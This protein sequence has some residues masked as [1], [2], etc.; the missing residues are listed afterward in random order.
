MTDPNNKVQPS[1]IDPTAAA[2][3]AIL[4]NILHKENYQEEAEAI[5]DGMWQEYSD[6][7][8]YY[9]RFESLEYWDEEDEWYDTL[10][11]QYEISFAGKKGANV[12]TTGP[13]K[14]KVNK[15]AERTEAIEKAGGVT[16]G[17]G[18]GREPALPMA[19]AL[20]TYNAYSP[21]S[22]PA[23]TA[24]SAKSTEVPSRAADTSHLFNPTLIMQIVANLDKKYEMVTKN[25]QYNSVVPAAISASDLKMLVAGYDHML[26]TLNLKFLANKYGAHGNAYRIDLRFGDNVPNYFANVGGESM[27]Q[28][29]TYSIAGLRNLL[30]S[31]APIYS[32]LASSHFSYPKAINGALARMRNETGNVVDLDTVVLRVSSSTTVNMIN[33]SNKAKGLPTYHSTTEFG[34]SQQAKEI[35]VNL[36][37][38]ALQNFQ[39]ALRISDSALKARNGHPSQI[40]PD[41]PIPT[42]HDNSTRGHVPLWRYINCGQDSF[43]ANCPELEDVVGALLR[44]PLHCV[45]HY[46]YLFSGVYGPWSVGAPVQANESE[47]DFAK[48]VPEPLQQKIRLFFEDC[49][50]DSCFNL[51]WKAIEE[52]GHVLRHEGT[53]TNVLQLLQM[54]HQ[55]ELLDFYAKLDE[56][57]EEEDKQGENNDK[58]LDP[59]AENKEV[60]APTEVAASE[61]QVVSTPTTDGSVAT[62]AT[63]N[64]NKKANKILVVSS[65]PVEPQASDL[66]LP[67]NSSAIYDPPKRVKEIDFIWGLVVQEGGLKGRDEATDRERA[68]TRGD[69]AAVVRAAEGV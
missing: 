28:R 55:K 44:A 19:D 48:S 15:A 27:Y 29:K 36:A 31:G 68:I 6:D 57:D 45:Y 32:E 63:T 40:N 41:A 2:D 4:E 30:R 7:P 54:R 50:A 56:E 34:N 26:N 42:A 64:S 20:P 21:S 69:V 10:A 43:H 8:A 18:R 33:A 11:E 61:Q 59:V 52:F 23:T 16:V 3:A 65:A 9:D 49:V 17:R 24:T 47:N 66:S 38:Q 25:Q 62:D 51:K 39:Q 35:A 37:T 46:A 12:K 60:D 67:A 1:V 14:G 5:A 53:M 22:P 58:S 13:K